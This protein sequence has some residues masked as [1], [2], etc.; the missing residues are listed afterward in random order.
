[1]S[2]YSVESVFSATDR[3]T[4]PLSKMQNRVAK[5][6]RSVESGVGKL[7]KGL[8]ATNQKLNSA[9]TIFGATGVVAAGAFGKVIQIGAQFEQKVTNAVAKF[10][11]EIQKGSAEFRAL[12]DAARKTG[13][14]TEF[15]ASQAADALDFLA[16]A[17]FDAKQAVA[18]LPGVVDLATASGLDLATATD[19]ASDALGAF[20]LQTKDANQLSKNLSRVND[21][22]AKTSTSANTTVEALFEAMKD[23]APVATAAGASIETF[24]ALAGT[25][26]NS[27]IKASKAGTTLKNIFLSLSA[28]TAGAQKIF[29]RLGIAT[30]DSEGNV[31]DVTDVFGDLSEA[32]KPLGE[33]DQLAAIEGIF[34]KIPIAGVNVLLQ[35]GSEKLKA[36]RKQLEDAG[37]SAGNMA[38]IMRNTVQGSI[39]SLKSAVEGVTISLFKQSEG[40]I[41]SSIDRMTEWVRANEELIAQ[42]VGGFISKII[43]NLDTIIIVAKN[44]VAAFLLFKAVTITMQ[45]FAATMTLV[46]GGIAAFNAITAIMPKVLA[47]ARTGML[48]LNLA[49][50]ANPVGLIVTGIGLLIAAGAAL[51]VAWDPVKE[52]FVDLWEKLKSGLGILGTV[53]SGF[54]SLF[55]GLGDTGDDQKTGGNADAKTDVPV[56]SP[57]ERQARM[58]EEQRKTTTTEV[59]IKDESGKAV[60]TKGKANSGLQLQSSGGF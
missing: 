28:P 60:I 17:G 38:G 29:K 40:G 46:N 59:T 7:N 56:S 34:G 5:F 3:M 42:N 43:D 25:L 9:A 52:F 21:V 6:G 23:G 58:I 55:G 41:K 15:S 36:Y 16:M 53:A 54:G 22:L 18:A 8:A 39:N 1:M 50:A 20:N 48:L 13:A 45:A 14:T 51:I 12:E 57:L 49:F 11:G 35:T 27:G 37:G 44:A 32:L 4:G 2:K 33:A 47:A 31:R 10:P 19:I 24:A 30:K 26:A